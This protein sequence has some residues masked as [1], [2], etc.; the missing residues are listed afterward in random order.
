VGFFGAAAFVGFFVAVD[1]F[2][3]SVFVT[4]FVAG[5]FFTAGASTVSCLKNERIQSMIFFMCYGFILRVT[6]ISFY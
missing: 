4:F 2:G 5:F 6:P 3:V 1:F